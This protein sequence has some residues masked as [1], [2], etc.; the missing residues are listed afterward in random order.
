MKPIT[1]PELYDFFDNVLKYFGVVLNLEIISSD[2]H[3]AS[4]TWGRVFIRKD[5][6]KLDVK[7]QGLT[8]H[9]V[10]HRVFAPI[11]MIN[12]LVWR[13]IAKEEGIDKTKDFT[14]II[15][16]LWVNGGFVFDCSKY[17][18]LYMNFL[19]VMGGK[20]FGFMQEEVNE[21]IVKKGRGEELKFSNKTIQRVFS[22]LF[23]DT[24]D[25]NTRVRELAR[26]LK[27]IVNKIPPE[28]FSG[29]GLGGCSLGNKLTEKEAD[30]LA[31]EL[32]KIAPNLTMDD[33]SELLADIEIM[34]GKEGDDKESRGI[35]R[36]EG[37][38]KT[39]EREIY[40]QYRKWQIYLKNITMLNS[41]WGKRSKIID[42]GCETWRVGDKIE[43]L[44]VLTTV[45][46][47]GIAIPNITTVK[48]ARSDKGE[49]ERGKGSSIC[50]VVD[51]SASTYGDVIDR[52]VEACF[53]IVE[54][55]R[56]F[57]DKVSL[58]TFSGG[59]YVKGAIEPSFD[60]D[61]VEDKL[62]RLEGA[63]GTVIAPALKRAR[64]FAVK[65][66][67]Q[68]TYI[69]TDCGV[70]D[71][72][73]AFTILEELAS[74]GKIVLFFVSTSDIEDKDQKK[75]RNKIKQLGG[76]AYLIPRGKTFTEEAIIEY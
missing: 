3:I 74:Y 43:D 73:R 31:K 64:D 50:L 67:K 71:M 30:Q 58:L 5:G 66:G 29:W 70:W 45:Q 33:I 34:N 28:G 48:R 10:G 46:T 75:F 69:A 7:A 47:S 57:G 68:T 8:C 52:E 15:S 62:V 21:N 49:T 38:E 39:K 20:Q 61:H 32:A 4:M 11:T 40:Y 35:G 36:G 54:N 12:E 55:A 19:D 16:D 6:L 24:R 59:L 18:K 51:K 13:A 14:N 17:S 22:T 25:I 53:A 9:E 37:T 27:D 65:E 56:H 41:Y 26:I 2:K 60:Y 44:D 76:S 63:G 1:K 72:E 42:A 23:Y